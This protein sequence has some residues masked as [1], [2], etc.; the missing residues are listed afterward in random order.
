MMKSFQRSLA[1]PKKPQI[2]NNRKKMN[3]FQFSTLKI[4]L[5]LSKLKIK[6]Q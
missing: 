5:F 3:N 6:S 1:T 2:K 4:N